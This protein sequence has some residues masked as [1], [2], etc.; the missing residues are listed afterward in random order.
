M[1]GKSTTLD[2]SAPIPL[3]GYKDRCMC[4]RVAVATLAQADMVGELVFRGTNAESLRSAVTAG[5]GVMLVPKS[6]IPAGLEAWDDGP[7]P[8]PPAVYGG[9]FVRE[10]A[11]NDTLNQLADRFAETLRPAAAPAPEAAVFAGSRV[12]PAQGARRSA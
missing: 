10:G 1:R 9:V 4:H 2:L 7:L 3:V 8:P 11:V 6:R 12:P 5:V